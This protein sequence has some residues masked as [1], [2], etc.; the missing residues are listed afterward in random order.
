ML[1]V[2]EGLLGR[3]VLA[4]AVFFI[5]VQYWAD[6]RL[7][8]FPKAYAPG[9]AIVMMAVFTTALLMLFAERLIRRRGGRR[10]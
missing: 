5:V 10:P 9:P 8:L 6:I 4:S 1:P 3:V 7:A 2:G